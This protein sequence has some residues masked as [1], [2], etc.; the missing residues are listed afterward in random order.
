M[1]RTLLLIPFLSIILLVLLTPQAQPET[2]TAAQ[3][4]PSESV[5]IATAKGNV[6]LSLEVARTPSE[7]M[8]GLM[9]RKKLPERHGMIF[10]FHEERPIGFW[11]K[12]TYIPLDILFIEHT[13]RIITIA[14]HTTPESTA[15]IPSEG[16]VNAV[17]ELP[18]GSAKT[19]GIAK[20]DKV[21]YSWFHD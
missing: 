10:L 6:A 1:K 4:L 15:L 3:I 8:R 12:N 17:I 14:E 9:F 19:L 7:Q 16:N 20:G 18:A 5:T 21:H 2:L 11:M 13:G